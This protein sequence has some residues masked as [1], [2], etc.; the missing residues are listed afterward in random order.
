M[1]IILKFFINIFFLLKIII[2]K[3][4]PK[5]ILISSY[6]HI[7]NSSYFYI[8]Y[9]LYF[10]KNKAYNLK[11]INK[12]PFDE[13]KI[14]FN[15]NLITHCCIMNDKEYLKDITEDI[16][17]FMHYNKIIKW[18]DILIHLNIDINDFTH[19]LYVN[20]NLDEISFNTRYLL[21]NN[22]VLYV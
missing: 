22:E 3:L 1:I 21:E 5:Y 2:I 6:T 14:Y 13:N 15:R 17:M 11:I 19:I 7:Y 16:R 20:N 8:Y 4:L 18:K 10:Y 12:L 9:Y